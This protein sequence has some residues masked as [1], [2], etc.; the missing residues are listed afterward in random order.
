M[1]CA[2]SVVIPYSEVVTETPFLNALTEL[3]GVSKKVTTIGGEV[4]FP[5]FIL[6]FYFISLQRKYR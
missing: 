6:P 2:H 3:G 4:Y 5:L 1:K